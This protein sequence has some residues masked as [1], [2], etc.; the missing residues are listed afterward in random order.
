MTNQLENYY[1]VIMAGGGGTRLWPLSTKKTPKQLVK[2]LG[3]ETLFQ[4]SVRRLAGL[5]DPKRIFVVTVKD[6]V[7]ILRSQTPEIPEE[8]FL[9]EPFPKGTASVVGYAATY[10]KRLN[11][12]AVLA[13][14]TADHF[15]KNV[16]EFHNLLK[17]A[18]SAANEK[19]LITLGIQPT[20][21]ATG[22][23]YIQKGEPVKKF[24]DK[25]AFKVKKFIEK[26]D[27]Q[28]AKF[29]FASG[30]YDWNSGMFIWHVDTILKEFE[31]QMPAFTNLLND[32]ET[33]LETGTFEDKLPEIWSKI[34]PQTIDYGIMEHA[35]NAIV[36][37]VSE[38]G[39]FD[40]GSWESLFFVTDNDAEGNVNLAQKFV[41]MDTKDSLVF[42][43]SKERLIVTLGVDNIVIVESGNTIL[44]CDRKKSQEIKNVVKYLTDNGLE[45]YL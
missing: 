32:L 24:Y 18:Y 17:S 30:G 36:L 38:L 16:N 5:F 2:I 31:R 4:I 25:W 22:Y 9:I 43:K 3:E 23:G 6:Q 34:T 28:N 15:I 19:Y 41:A 35:E 11:P 1:A 39:W 29:M 26:P 44:V 14:L 20:Y 21:V 40:V 45:D 10:I 12:N 13:I 33:A 7:E 8:N 37:P 42:S 27:L